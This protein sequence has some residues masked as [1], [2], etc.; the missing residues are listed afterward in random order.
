MNHFYG[1]I[2]TFD[3]VL[4]MLLFCLCIRNDLKLVELNKYQSFMY[5]VALVGSII[6]IGFGIENLGL[7]IESIKYNNK[8]KLIVDS[9]ELSYIL[10][11]SICYLIYG[12]TVMWTKENRARK[13][14]KKEIINYFD[15]ITKHKFFFFNLYSGIG[16]VLLAVWFYLQRY[17]II[18]TF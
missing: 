10:F 5:A 16:L 2:S 4:F 1:T 8:I 6:G 13:K 7:W 18:Q 15:F 11:L 17:A 12:L 14:A 3:V 9:S